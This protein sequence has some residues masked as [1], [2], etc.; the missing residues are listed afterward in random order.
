MNHEKTKKEIP[1]SSIL[2]NDHYNGGGITPQPHLKDGATNV[3]FKT[4]SLYPFLINN[5]SV[6]SERNNAG[7]EALVGHHPLGYS[8]FLWHSSRNSLYARVCILLQEFCGQL[9]ALH[10][11]QL[12]LL[13]CGMLLERSDHIPRKLQQDP[14]N[15]TGYWKKGTYQCMWYLTLT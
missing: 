6:E 4:L 3:F 12:C 8:T 9:F 10:V 5:S 15:I 2:H 7:V 11:Q 13:F 14:A 1:T